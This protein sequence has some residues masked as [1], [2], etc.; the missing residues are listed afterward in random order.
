MCE[1]NVLFRLLHKSARPCYYFAFAILILLQFHSLQK[2]FWRIFK[3]ETLRKK[4]RKHFENFYI[5]LSITYTVW[6]IFWEIVGQQ[7]CIIFNNILRNIMKEDKFFQCF[8]LNVVCVFWFT[9]Q[10]MYKQINWNK[11]FLFWKELFIFTE[12]IRHFLRKHGIVPLASSW[13]TLLHIILYTLHDI[14]III[15]Y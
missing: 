5:S 10:N 1:W 15:I 3:K 6:N 8:G 7:Y 2:T 13:R 11:Y 14:K 9:V 4:G 12:F